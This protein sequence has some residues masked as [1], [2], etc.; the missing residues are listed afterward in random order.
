MYSPILHGDI[1]P[2]NILLDE[3]L[4]PKISDFEIE[5]LLST[6]G[7]QHTKNIIGSI[8]YLDP[9]YSQTRFVTPKSDV[10]SFGVVLLEM[11]N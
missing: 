1:K 10:Y 2:S 7:A 11:T 8:G 9:L 6:D 4:V 5:R 3:N